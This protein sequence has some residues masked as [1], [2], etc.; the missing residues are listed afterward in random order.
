MNPHA[1]FQT[2]LFIYSANSDISMYMHIY[3]H[4]YI[5][6]LHINSTTYIHTHIFDLST[7]QPVLY[8]R[9]NIYAHA[10]N[11]TTKCGE[12]FVSD[13]EKPQKMRLVTIRTYYLYY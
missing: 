8:M 13:N 6:F 10:H 9:I 2:Y 4:V 1:L 7:L 11:I 12:N 5:F 3:V